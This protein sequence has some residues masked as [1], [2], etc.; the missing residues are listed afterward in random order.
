MKMVKL[1]EKP[2]DC[3]GAIE[4]F[5]VDRR[6]ECSEARCPDF[7][8]PWLGS[9]IECECGKWYRL[10]S[11]KLESEY[12][13]VQYTPTPRDLLEHTPVASPGRTKL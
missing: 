5:L 2:H 1:V 7:V 8:E 12:A 3:Q 4:S 6:I 9:V 10:E 13:W 11:F